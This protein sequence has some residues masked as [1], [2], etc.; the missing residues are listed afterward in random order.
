VLVELVYHMHRMNSRWAHPMLDVA[1]SGADSA[2]ARAVSDAR[3]ANIERH[4][5]HAAAGGASILQ[6]VLPDTR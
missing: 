3:A 6:E 1:R 4:S 5:A 2:R